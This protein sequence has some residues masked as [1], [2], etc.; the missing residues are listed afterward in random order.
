MT[1]SP[2]GHRFTADIHTHILPKGWPDV[3]RKYGVDGFAVI[4][5]H[6]AGCVRLMQNGRVF[7]E[8]A[9]N[10]WDPD[11]RLA[12]CD[13]DGVDLQVLSTVPVMFSYWA[14]AEP[15][16]E[17]SRVLNDHIAGVA[18]YKPRRFV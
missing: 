7:R 18:A 1:Q 4:E 14:P 9:A 12:D 11:V 16:L 5:H 13:R 6:G 8:I 17:L 3:G 15:A 10:S 2:D